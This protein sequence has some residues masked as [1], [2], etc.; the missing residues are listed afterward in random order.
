[1]DERYIVDNVEH[2]WGRLV[3]E[4]GEVLAAAGKSLRF[5]L[6]SYDPTLPVE[7]RET[8]AAWLKR[9]IDDLKDAIQRIEKYL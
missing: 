4:S 5:G 6:D 1:M 2:A 9:E 3:E 7:E 8:N